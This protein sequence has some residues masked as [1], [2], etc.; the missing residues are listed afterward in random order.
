VKSHIQSTTYL[1]TF[2]VLLLLHYPYLYYFTFPQNLGHVPGLLPYLSIPPTYRLDLGFGHS[3]RKSSDGPLPIYATWR[4]CCASFNSQ[5]FYCPRVVARVQHHSG[6]YCSQGPLGSRDC[7]MYLLI[8][9]S[10]NRGAHVRSPK[11]LLHER[12]PGQHILHPYR[13]S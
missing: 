2:L 10:H 4:Y 1:P 13:G 11:R 3:P 12:R 5:V 6:R 8:S 9:I 7:H